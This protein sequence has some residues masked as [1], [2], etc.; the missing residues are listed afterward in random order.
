MLRIFDKESRGRRWDQLSLAFERILLHGLSYRLMLSVA[1]IPAMFSTGPANAQSIDTNRPSFSF[2]PNVVAPGR[3]QLETGIAYTRSD[4][5]TD[6]TSLPGAELR[7]GIADDVELFAS[8]LNWTSADSAGNDTSGLADMA[9][10][11]KV[12]I[13]SP[14]ARTNMALLLQISV[15]IGDSDL[16]SDRW[17][18]SAAFVWAYDGALTLAGTVKV[19]DFES[20]LQVD[21]GLNLV[22]S[23]TDTS[24]AFVEW[25]ANLPESGGSTHWLN[26]GYLWLL[27]DTMQL[28]LNAGLGLNDR[29]GDYRLGAGFSVLFMQ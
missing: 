25:E 3:W 11:A 15:P 6:E 5:D 24:S 8:S 26:G 4:S 9:L 2:S 13:S 7:F 28:D 19:S 22:F 17:D 12:N 21:N 29:A 10:G 14:G 1:L 23:I 16:T 20:G 27:D 18:P